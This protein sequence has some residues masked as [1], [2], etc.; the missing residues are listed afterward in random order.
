MTK[1]ER[2][3]H[4]AARQLVKALLAIEAFTGDPEMVFE[5]AEVCMVQE[6]SK[7]AK[8]A[9]RALKAYYLGDSGV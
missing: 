2:Q 4:R 5:D 6:T 1:E 7:G 8:D 3:S 9:L